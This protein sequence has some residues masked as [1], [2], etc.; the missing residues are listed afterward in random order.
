MTKPTYT[1]T[2]ARIETHLIY[3]RE[4]AEKTDKH[5]EKLNDTVADQQNQI[6]RNTTRIGLA[7]KIIGGLVTLAAIVI[8]ILF[9][10]GVF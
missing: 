4:H 3:I 10:T 6:T 5:L 8:P 9:V 2:V 7:F 1:E